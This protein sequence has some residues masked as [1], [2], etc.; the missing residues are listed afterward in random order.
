MKPAAEN[1]TLQLI[2]KHA[3]DLRVHIKSVLDVVV[4][5][6]CSLSTSTVIKSVIYF[7]CF[8]KTWLVVCKF[9]FDQNFP[10]NI[11]LL[12]LEVYHLMKNKK[13]CTFCYTGSSIR[14]CFIPNASYDQH[15]F[16][17]WKK[18]HLNFSYRL[19]LIVVK[20]KK[21]CKLWVIKEIIVLML[22]TTHVYEA[23]T[24]LNK[25]IHCV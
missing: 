3:G 15:V 12:N 4:G 7:L 13:A 2:G 14:K 21:N 16:P 1:R 22:R 8:K 10:F 18:H 6:S 19:S 9:S 17:Q 23:E 5:I 20:E 11:E 24:T 25:H